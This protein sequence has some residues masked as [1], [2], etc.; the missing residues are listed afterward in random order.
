MPKEKT[1]AKIEM[2]SADLGHALYRDMKKN[3]KAILEFSAGRSTEIE[4]DGVKGTATLTISFK[5][6]KG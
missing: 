2:L 3:G 4:V 1:V 6:K 5:P